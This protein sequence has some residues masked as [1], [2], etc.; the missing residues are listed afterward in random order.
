M[1]RYGDMPALRTHRT[2][3][4]PFGAVLAFCLAAMLWGC[5]QLPP[6]FVP[7]P[8]AGRL[9]DV[10]F[11]AQEDHQC[12]PAALAMVLN[13]LGDPASPEDISRA[14]YRESLRGTLSLDLTLYARGRGHTARFLK[15]SAQD[16]ADAVNA[17]V[18]PLVMVNEGLSRI[19]VLHYM[20]VTGYD[21]EGVV[22]NSGRSRGVRMSWASFL[23]AW[24]DA[25]R[26]MLLV[27]PGAPAKGAK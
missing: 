7:P 23:S 9:N 10:P 15:G 14:I 21:G 6:G 11:H 19:R 18:P 13:R 20:V 27:T 26:W 2:F 3:G 24:E 22:A 8:G 12:G 4:P 25:D 16:I 17:G 1:T 5:A